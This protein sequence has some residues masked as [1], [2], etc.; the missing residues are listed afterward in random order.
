[1]SL[2]AAWMQRTCP[3]GGQRFG[4]IAHRQRRQRSGREQSV[5]D[6]ERFLPRSARRT[7]RIGNGR[8]LARERAPP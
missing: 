3:L 4:A 2:A 6:Y 7:D 5:P 1:M 8:R